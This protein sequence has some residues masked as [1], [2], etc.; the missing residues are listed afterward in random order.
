M[1]NLFFNLFVCLIIITIGIIYEHTTTQKLKKHFEKEVKKA[2]LYKDMVELNKRYKVLKKS[3]KLRKYETINLYLELYEKTFSTKTIGYKKEDFLYL[4]TQKINTV[5]IDML[6]E[7]L[8]ECSEPVRKLVL[9]IAKVHQKMLKLEYPKEYKIVKMANLIKPI[10]IMMNEI[11]A[12]ISIKTFKYVLKTFD[13][14]F[15]LYK[16]SKVEKLLAI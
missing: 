2:Y 13:F 5:D 9:Q 12:I 10:K 14:N 15:S 7:E 16:D 3:N 8:K 11:F 1:D 6:V 4:S